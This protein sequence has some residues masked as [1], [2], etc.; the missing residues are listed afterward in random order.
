MVKITGPAVA[1][2]KVKI[3]PMR[4]A[5][6]THEAEQLLAKVGQL[7][8]GAAYALARELT[9]I[10]YGVPEDVVYVIGQSPRLR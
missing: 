3:K 1:M 8:P 4:V 6:A 7:S 9:A 2:P 10:F 5:K